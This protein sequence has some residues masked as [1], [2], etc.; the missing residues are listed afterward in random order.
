MSTINIKML[1][2]S[3]LAHLKNNIEKITTLIQT[4]DNC[5]WIYSEFAQPV[6]STKSITIEDFDLK[7]NPESS[8]KEVDFENS[9]RLYEHLN[10][11]PRY[12]LTDEKFWLWLYLEKFYKISRTIMRIKNSTTILDHWTFKQGK[13]RGLMFGILSRCYFRVEFTVDENEKDKYKLTKWVIENPERFRNLTWRVMSS[14]TE[15]IKSIVSGE[16]RAI[17]IDKLSEN[18]DVY[19]KIGKY[20]SE[21]GSVRLLDVIS[22]DDLSNMVYNKMLELLN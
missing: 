9:I 10:K 3:N 20:V 17:E 22:H 8:D 14:K 4:N 11:L 21:I 15:L 6:F 5:N 13:R 7:E 2:E 12:I 16:Y 1:T 18:N 19:P